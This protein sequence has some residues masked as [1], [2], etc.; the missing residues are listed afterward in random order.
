M[1]AQHFHATIDFIAESCYEFHCTL[2]SGNA[3]LHSWQNSCIGAQYVD[4]TSYALRYLFY[5]FL[6]D[7]DFPCRNNQP[8]G[9]P[10]VAALPRTS[11]SINSSRLYAY[12]W[13]ARPLRTTCT[14]SKTVKQQFTSDN[15]RCSWWMI[16]LWN[17]YTPKR[18]RHWSVNDESPKR[19]SHIN[20]LR[21]DRHQ[22]AW[23]TQCV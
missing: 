6:R 16:C 19:Q 18:P 23:L 14:Q 7:V 2:I 12:K 4:N 11:Q 3:W 20:K 8:G 5:S 13:Y 10:W 21:N 1:N 9:Q 17:C 15:G 22:I